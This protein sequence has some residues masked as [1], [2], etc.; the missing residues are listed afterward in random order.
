MEQTKRTIRYCEP[1]RL[2]ALP[3]KTIWAHWAT[4]DI[5][6]YYMQISE[7][8]NK[9]QWEPMGNILIKAFRKFIDDD[10]FVDE[11]LNLYKSCPEKSLTIISDIIKEK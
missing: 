11:C 1:T 9:P 10:T 3:Y 2:D 8:L 6:E 4:K 7:D 5:C